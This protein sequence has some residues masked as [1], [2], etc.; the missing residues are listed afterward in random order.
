M[1]EPIIDPITGKPKEGGNN[2]PPGNGQFVISAEDWGNIKGRLDTFEKMGYGSQ[3]HAPTP[4]APAGPT[5]NDRIKDLDTDIEALS[6]KIDEAVAN[7]KPVSALLNA[8]DKLTSSRLR[9]QIKHEDID[10]AFAQGIETIDQLS[11]TVTRAQMPHIDLVRKDYDAALSSLPPEQRMNPKMRQAAYNIAVGQNVSAII[12]AENEKNLRKSADGDPPA[13]GDNS[14]SSGGGDKDIVPKPEDVLSRD[15]I[16]ALRS[17]GQS[18]D[19][20]YKSMGYKDW[21]DYW[22]KTGKAY[23]T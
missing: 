2:A 20:Y 19:D 5:F 8:R 1:T 10:P 21:P 7:G 3:Q 11:D 15:T 13:P 12:S 18:A 22:T 17:K 14:R 4:A 6:G 9:L 16:K 23:F